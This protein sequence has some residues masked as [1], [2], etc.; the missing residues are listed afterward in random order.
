MAT[1]PTP[2]PQSPKTVR[3]YAEND[4]LIK[5]YLEPFLAT[6]TEHEFES[7]M[8]S[9]AGGTEKAM[10]VFYMGDIPAKNSVRCVIKSKF[11]NWTL[12]EDNPR[13]SSEKNVSKRN[14]HAPDELDIEKL[15]WRYFDW[16]GAWE[17]TS[18]RSKKQAAAILQLDELLKEPSK[19]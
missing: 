4:R 15:F 17:G 5:V 16:H 18:K 12:F 7:N 3:W 6:A 11:G 10:G 9:S 19:P 8:L 2:K 1:S 13:G 14:E